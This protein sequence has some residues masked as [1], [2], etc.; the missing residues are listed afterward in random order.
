VE[1][2][3]QIVRGFPVAL[4]DDVDVVTA[5]LPEP[6][7]VLEARAQRVSVQ[8]EEVEIAARIYDP[9]PVGSAIERL[10]DVQRLIAA[11]VYSRHHDGYVRQSACGAILPSTE[12]W[13]VP[14]V[15]QLLGEYVVEISGLILERLTAQSSFSRPSYRE[16]VR[17]N[18]AFMALT[19][20]RAISYWSCYYRRDF[21]R[22]EYPVLVA[23][24][25]LRQRDL[26]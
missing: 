16:F 3:K 4:R 19:E 10:N 1:A 15:V 17:A 2:A 18:S 12:P 23:L 8:G 24:H 13:V 11:C 26:G 22:G 5:V 21:T 9:D 20:Q 7:H 14:Y 25:K 6:T